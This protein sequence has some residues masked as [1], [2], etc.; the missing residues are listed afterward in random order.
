M[1]DR[2]IR[3]SDALEAVDR[4]IKELSIDPAFV[5][6]NGI[7]DVM[8]VK[9][10][11]LVIPTANRPQGHWEIYTVSPFDGEDCRCSECGAIGCV[12]YWDYCPHCGALMEGE[13]DGQT[14]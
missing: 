6:K 11:I 10:Y 5:R 13:V 14:N 2:L 8:G 7:I 12:P 3:E 4:R 9:K 1:N